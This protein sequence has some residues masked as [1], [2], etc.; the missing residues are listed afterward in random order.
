[1]R[2]LLRDDIF[3]FFPSVFNNFI[4]HYVVHLPSCGFLFD[5]STFTLYFSETS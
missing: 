5:L 1:M 4:I 2:F 3:P